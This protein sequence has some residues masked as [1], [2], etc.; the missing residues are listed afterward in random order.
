MGM[1]CGHARKIESAC[2]H[3]R[4]GGGAQVLVLHVEYR[5]GER[6]LNISHD[7]SKY[8]AL[9]QKMHR[10]L[11][12]SPTLR[13]YRL[14][15]NVPQILEHT[16]SC[17]T[18]RLGS[19][20]V[21]A[22]WLV[23]REVVRAVNLFSKL[24]TGLF[25]AVAGLVEALQ[26]I[27]AAAS[28]SPAHPR[29]VLKL[30]ATA[31]PRSYDA[32]LPSA[33]RSMRRANIDS[34]EDAAGGPDSGSTQV[35]SP[36]LGMGALREKAFLRRRRHAPCTERASARLK[37]NFEAGTSLW[38]ELHLPLRPPGARAALTLHASARCAVLRETSRQTDCRT[39]RRVWP[40]RSACS[41]APCAPATP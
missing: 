32:D 18:P 20:E 2:L 27:V 6:C 25:P 22:V 14:V 31:T 10:L 41:S 37:R 9:V 16:H 38:D 7:A 1:W 39:A 30:N 19:F 36:R 8:E 13:N 40:P 29:L 21:S 12:T 4:G 35:L 24:A 3:R 28:S 15:C 5:Y 11:Q 23:G 26:D 33:D 17:P 34:C